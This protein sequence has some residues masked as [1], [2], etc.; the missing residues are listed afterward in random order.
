[1]MTVLRGVANSRLHRGEFVLDDGLHAGARAQDV[2]IVGD[3]DRELVELFGNLLAAERRQPLQTQIENGLGLLQRQPRGAVVGHPVA[4]IVDQRDHRL[5]VLGRPV[6]R[7]QR[8][9][10]GVRIGRGADNANDLVDIG[11]RNREADQDMGAV[12]RL[13]EQEFGAPRH[14]LFAERDEQRQQVLQ[15]HHLRPAGVERHHVGGKFVCSGV[16]R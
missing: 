12:A 14:H 1:M 5:D 4:G 3:F 10:R 6:A 15:V 13:V 7:H 2:E 8:V 11:D 16:K 9:A